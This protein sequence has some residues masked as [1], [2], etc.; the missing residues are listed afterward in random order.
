MLKT[1]TTNSQLGLKTAGRSNKF[2]LCLCLGPE[3][4]WAYH[5]RFGAALLQDGFCFKLL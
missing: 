3:L 5:F 2:P 4:L 1:Q